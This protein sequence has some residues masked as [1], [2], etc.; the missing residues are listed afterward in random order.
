MA[1]FINFMVEDHPSHSEN[2]FSISISNW[3]GEFSTCP[4]SM[5]FFTQNLLKKI[6]N[7]HREPLQ[8]FY[9]S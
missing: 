1:I 2:A 4:I 5:G 7:F 8:N 9:G 6:H 3:M